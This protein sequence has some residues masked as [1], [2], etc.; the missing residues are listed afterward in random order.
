MSWSRPKIMFEPTGSWSRCITINPNMDVKEFKRR[1]ETL[2]N[3]P[4]AA[5]ILKYK[6][7][8]GEILPDDKCLGRLYIR[9]HDTV[10]IA[11]AKS[12]MVVEVGSG[13]RLFGSNYIDKLFELNEPI[14]QHA[15]DKL[16]RTLIKSYLQRAPDYDTFNTLYDIFGP[17]GT[18]GSYKILQIKTK[19]KSSWYTPSNEKRLMNTLVFGYLR[20]ENKYEIS[21]PLAIKSLVEMYADDPLLRRALS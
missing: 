6:G 15:M 20:R 1:Y 3:I 11:T 18:D 4:T 19:D 14:H 13:T 17:F 16:K 10:T 9:D 8:K 7:Y 5:Q 2:K 21:I 12:G